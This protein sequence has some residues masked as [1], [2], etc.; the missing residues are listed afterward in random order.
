[1]S[2]FKKSNKTKAYEQKLSELEK[3][4]KL[5]P[6]YFEEKELHKLRRDIKGYL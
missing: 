6:R 4:L 1:M 3:I 2:I 5:N